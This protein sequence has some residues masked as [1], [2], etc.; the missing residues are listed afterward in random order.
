MK[1]QTLTEKI[2]SRGAGKSVRAGEYVWL[3]FDATLTTDISAPITINLVEEMGVGELVDKD[4]IYA[5]TDHYSA[6]PGTR[7]A[8]AI[9][10]LRKFCR[11]HGIPNFFD[12]GRSGVSH[13]QML[14]ERLVRPGELLAG[15]DSHT[16]SSGAVGAFAT[17]IGSTELAG[18]WVMGKMWLPVPETVRVNLVGRLQG[19]SKAKDAILTLA[20]AL[21]ANGALQMAIEFGGPGLASLSMRERFTLCNMGVEIG[22]TNAICE[23]DET[24]REWFGGIELDE[25]LAGPDEGA[26]YAKVVTLDLSKVVPVVAKPYSPDNVE[27]AA[28]L[29][30]QRIK[31]DQIY[32]GTCTN[33]SFDDIKIFAESL[34]AHGPGVHPESRAIV[35]PSSQGAYAEL[36][37]AGVIAELQR[38][39]CQIMPPGCG[40][41]IG[42][43]WGVLG[44]GEVGFFTSNR[45]FRGRTGSRD[46]KTYLGSP[47]VAGIVAA[48]GCI[49]ADEEIQPGAGDAVT[50]EVTEESA[51]A[52]GRVTAIE[53]IS[54]EKSKGAVRA[55]AVKR[56]NINTDEIIPARYCNTVLPAELAPHALEDYD[57]TLVSRLPPGSILV[58]RENFGCGSSREVAAVTL[59]A[60]GVGGIVAGSFGAIFERNCINN[61]LP[62]MR[63][64]EAA[65]RIEDG[66]LLFLDAEGGEL[67]NITRQEKYTF[68]PLSGAAK[69][70]MESGSL[71]EYM[72]SA[73]SAGDIPRKR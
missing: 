57:P 17:G 51:G 65:R 52:A 20:G 31:V 47:Y 53:G 46:S 55:I 13:A 30:K 5:F 3:D 38:A 73:V 29:K 68:P 66:D 60:A 49:D 25:T 21:T 59:A 12:I 64:R 2:L 39:G 56:D 58:G 18:L 44:D 16:C 40:A 42:T 33:G 36:L 23:V 37:E 28:E 7:E 50:I 45:N 4:R 72:K 61:A 15:T 22:A 54:E 67:I 26:A 32:V 69:E 8:G 35:V 19:K 63:S 10:L 62:V 43:H 48:R 6:P 24:T 27:A 14:E 71:A 11:K 1:P 41:C 70:V 34:R 9:D